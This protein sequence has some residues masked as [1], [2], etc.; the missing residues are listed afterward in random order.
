MA[1]SLSGRAIAN[2]A[3]AERGVAT[4]DAALS[5]LSEGKFLPALHALKHDRSSF[6][7]RSASHR[8][9]AAFTLEQVA[10]ALPVNAVFVSVLAGTH[11]GAAL[12]LKAGSTQVYSL[13]LPQFTMDAIR[14]LVTGRA[15]V[16]GRQISL[17]DGYRRFSRR[18][19]RRRLL[20]SEAWR[21]WDRTLEAVLAGLGAIGW[22]RLHRW[23]SDVL[24]LPVGS[25][26]VLSLPPALASLPVAAVHEPRSGR[27][28]L[29]DFAVRRVPDAS[30]LIHCERKAREAERE[31][32]ALLAVLDPGGDLACDPE[33]PHKCWHLGRAPCDVL[34]GDCATPSQVAVRLPDCTHYVHFGH[35]SR[36]RRHAVLELAQEA[37][38]AGGQA[39]LRDG[40]VRSMKL[41]HNRLSILA[42]CESG[43]LCGKRESELNGMAGSF[44][45]A[46]SACVIGCLWPVESSTTRRLVERTLNRHLGSGPGHAGLSPAQALRQ[47]QI[48]LR[49]SK[50]AAPLPG[51]ERHAVLH[52]RS[53]GQAPVVGNVCER[54][55][56]YWAA[57][58]CLGG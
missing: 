54:H 47:A 19:G 26:V 16:S 48:E 9:D 5:L 57:F 4:D 58:S 53:G 32:P 45:L 24:Q 50:A 38:V 17:A 37:G 30:W 18:L 49:D 51:K 11:G 31:A 8:P 20:Q 41:A 33:W 56:Y 21:D 25:E 13:S 23:L 39:G 22:N 3:G 12:A 27:Y 29:D 2:V 34:A 42:A 15:V 36:Q 1:K 6:G 10:A 28:F 46:G 52:L 7:T 14:A 44:L 55:L 40:Q 35:G 43:L